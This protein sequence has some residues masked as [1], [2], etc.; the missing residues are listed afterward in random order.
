MGTDLADGLEAAERTLQLA[1][2]EP[3]VSPLARGW[4]NNHGARNESAR[5]TLTTHSYF[6]WPVFYG[7]RRAVGWGGQ[8]GQG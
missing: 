2:A 1:L 3:E 6:G 4:A 5:P 7:T 8:V